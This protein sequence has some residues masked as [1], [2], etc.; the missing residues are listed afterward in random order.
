MSCIYGPQQF[1]TEDQGWIA[2]FLN[3]SIHDHAIT[4]YGDGK[5]VRD[6]LYVEDL[7]DAFLLAMKD[8]NDIPGQV[9]NIGGGP[10]NAISLIDLIAYMHKLDHLKIHVIYDTWRTG[11][12]KYYV[13]DTRKFRERTGWLPKVSYQ[14]GIA[15]IFSW[16]S[17]Y[18]YSQNQKTMALK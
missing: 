18:E 2:H 9:F 17:A 6:V 1:G 4:I 3:Q 5:Q 11:D 16:L 7:V 13:S 8:I 10:S 14:E 12:Q 15:N